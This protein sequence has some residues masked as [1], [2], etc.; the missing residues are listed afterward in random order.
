MTDREI[1]ERVRAHLLKQG[2]KAES[3]VTDCD[4]GLTNECRYRGDAGRMCAVG[5]LVSDEAYRAAME[6]SV[7]RQLELRNGMWSAVGRDDDLANALN[8][9]GIPARAST[10]QLLVELQSLHDARSVSVWGEELD[11][12]ASEFTSEGEYKQ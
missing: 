11:S 10:K 5:C 12:M 1:F 4:G 8:D 9:S 3:T 7:V 2:R 6:G